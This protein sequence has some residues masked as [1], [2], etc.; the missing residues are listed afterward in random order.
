[1]PDRREQR[2]NQRW[3]DVHLFGHRNNVPRE[4]DYTDDVIPPFSACAPGYSH[5][6]YND[7]RSLATTVLIESS[8]GQR[9]LAFTDGKEI[10]W[11][12]YGQATFEGP[13]VA[14]Y[15]NYDLEAG[16]LVG[17]VA[18]K[19]S[20]VRGRA[21]GGYRVMAILDSERKLALVQRDQQA[22]P[23]ISVNL[24]GQ[25]PRPFQDDG[26][27]LLV[28]GEKTG[29]D[30]RDVFAVHTNGIEVLVSDTYMIAFTIEIE[31]SYTLASAG[32]GV[33]YGG[34][35]PWDGADYA[36]GTHHGEGSKVSLTGMKL[37]YIAAGSNEA[38]VTMEYSTN[39][40]PD[41]ARATLTIWRDN[42]GGVGV[43]GPPSPVP[44]AGDP[45]AVPE[46]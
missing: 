23:R 30:D 33:A 43:A 3:Q 37:Q 5:L 38:N 46:L 1:M 40:I 4:G 9:H 32:M 31:G 8:D 12:E 20:L 2:E 45:P 27:P 15:H 39:W 28:V 19:T 10:T 13:V 6:N 41:A 42:D 11:H 14:R 24:A 36:F 34:I 18:Y 22:R 44:S 29:V 35:Y 26:Q 17:P 16:E 21:D 7:D 25:S